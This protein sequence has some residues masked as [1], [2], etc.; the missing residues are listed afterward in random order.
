[1]V[2]EQGF[3]NKP[4][5]APY[6]AQLSQ[7]GN[8]TVKTDH[9]GE[10][11]QVHSRYAIIDDH[12]VLASSGDFLDNSFN[13]S[14]NNTLAIDTPRT[15]IDG[16]GPGG[17][18]TIT[19]AFLFD[20][21]QMFNMDRFGGDKERM[22]NHIFNIGSIVEVYFGPNDNLVAELFSK[23]GNSLA[24]QYAV[25]QITDPTMAGIAANGW[26]FTEASFGW[27][28]YNAMNHK[29]MI[30]NVPA[31]VTTTINPVYL[32]VIDPLVITGS[33]NW[34][35]N[36]LNT[37]DEQV[38]VVHDLTLCYEFAIEM[39]ALERE[40]AGV[41]VVFG[42]VRTFKNVP[43][44][45]ALPYCDSNNIPGTIFAGDGGVKPEDVIT[46]GRGMYAM[47]I[48]TGFLRNISLVGLGDADGLYLYPDPLFGPTMPNEG[49]NLL[50]GSSYEANFYLYPMPSGTG[51]GGGGG[52]FGG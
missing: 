34:T 41:G 25:A 27:T 20:F 6:I 10:V 16:E 37:N 35:F 48:P 19:D 22:V 3:F 9:D 24:L 42:T 15:Y 52:G 32:N 50:P 43:V 36:G 26:G 40:A 31:D 18:Q 17:V 38:I 13:L 11:R 28:G 51:T 21:D 5:Y 2:T 44:P 46:D 23:Y 49:W 39:G 29:F 30:I 45:N 47:F 7:A 8:V 1:V 33:A 12:M 14:V 4:E